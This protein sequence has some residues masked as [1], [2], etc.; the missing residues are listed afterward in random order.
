ME[1]KYLGH[2]SFFIKTKNAKIV[3]DPFLPEST[4]LKFANTEADVV[5]ISHAHDDHSYSEGIKGEPLVLTW[6]GEYEKKEVRITGFRTFHDA[7]EGAERGENIMFKF[8][9]NDISLLHCGDLG[10]LLSNE[11]TDEIGGV[12]V[13]M[14]PVGGMTTIDAK[15]AVK[16]INQIEP[17]IVI[18]MHYN[19]DGLDQKTF[20]TL[21]DLQTFLKEISA[22]DVQ[23]IEKLSI[24]KEQLDPENMKV[25]VLSI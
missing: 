13:L 14:I 11:I 16:V 23:P 15:Q 19:Q 5:T 3:T 12:D 4:G 20:G 9:D 22:E 10:H 18:P 21:S 6:S 1:I 24:K 7:Q 25:V 8:E 17:S 2:S